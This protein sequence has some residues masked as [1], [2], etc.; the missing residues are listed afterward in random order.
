ML[1]FVY[2]KSY[3]IVNISYILLNKNLVQ[4]ILSENIP[5]RDNKY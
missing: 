1:F 5:I 2:L 3:L 4:L